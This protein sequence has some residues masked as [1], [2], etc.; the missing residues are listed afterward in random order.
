MEKIRIGILGCAAIAKRS[1]IPAILELADKFEL[2]AI[3][4]RTYDKAAEVSRAFNTEAIEGYENLLDRSDIDAVYVPLP[5]GLH[6]EW[7]TKSLQ[8]GKH[9][10]S[11]KSLAMDYSSAHRLVE[12]ARHKKLLLMENFMFRYHSQHVVVKDILDQEKLGSIR[13]FRSQFGFPPLDKNNFR[14]DK[15]IGG[16]ALLDAGAYT[17]RASQ[18]FLGPELEVAASTLYFDEERNSDIHGNATLINPKGLVAQI[19]FGFDNSYQCNY[20]FWG[21]KARLIAE[22]AFTPKL[23]EKP[24][25]L[26]EQNG[27]SKKLEA[28]PDNHFVNIL[29]AFGQGIHSGD[30]T[31]HLSD[32][33][34]QSRLL[35]QIRTRC[36][37][38]VYEGSNIGV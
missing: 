32:I 36:I 38:K 33:L 17:V 30:H 8:A 7:I 9:V 23:D 4:S 3:A 28:R 5:T 16:G 2:V 19:A 24:V 29:N 34:N 18:W 22:K 26:F 10:F 27:V 25:I 31:S 15:N 20:E 14:Y 12:L 11:E 35:E 6:D 37:K 1:V 13:L 21:S